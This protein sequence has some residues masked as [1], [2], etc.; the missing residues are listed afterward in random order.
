MNGAEV[1]REA[2]RLLSQQHWLA[3]GTIDPAGNP[4]VTYAPFAAVDGAFGVV[5]SRLAAHTANLLAHP[6]AS[7]LLVDTAAAPSDAYACAR[8][9]VSVAVHPM[10]AGSAQAADVWSALEA[11]HGTTVSVLRTLPDFHAI[12][13][14]PEQ[15]RLVGGFAM[16]HE[17]AGATLS[18][19]LRAAR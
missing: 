15:G 16:A 3:L 14:V 19:I 18:E 7:L 11:R 9:S 5:V 12:L 17:M 13:F 1:R 2:G 6:R 4:S 10:D 8:L